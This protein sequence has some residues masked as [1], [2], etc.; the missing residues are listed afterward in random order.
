VR[1]SGCVV[2]GAMEALR[3][4]DVYPKTHDD[5]KV[6]TLG[7]ALISICCYIFVAVLFLSEYRQWRSL[8]TVDMLDVDTTAKPDGRLPVNIDIYLPSLPCGELVTEVTDD[9]GSQQLAVTDTLHKLRM[10]R[11]GVPIDLPERVD[12]G[13]MIAP[14]F[15][16]RKVVRLMEEAQQHL[17]ETVEHFEHEEEENPDLTLEEHEAHREQL[18]Q[19][20]AQLQGRLSR[21]T[22]VAAAGEE[23]AMTDQHEHLEMSARELNAMHEEVSNSRIYSTQQRESVLANLHAMARSVARLRNGTSASSTNNLR[24]ALRIRLTI[25]KD[26]VQGFVSAKDIDRRDRYTNMEELLLDIANASSLLPTA[27]AEHVNEN[28]GRLSDSLTRLNAGLTGSA[29]REAEAVFERQLASLQA[30]LRGEDTLAD[31]YCGS[32]YGAS[33]DPQKCCNTCDD[34]RAAYAER[35]WGF[36]DPTTFEQCRRDAR[37]RSAKLQEGEGCNIYGTME[38]ARV[39]GTFSIAPVS[40]LPTSRLQRNVELSAD[41]AS[42]FNVTHQI[43]RLSFGT[44]FPGQHNPLDDIWTHS[45]GGAAVSRY[46][47]KVV[48]TTYEFIGG[49]SVHTNQFSVTQ[50]FKS[51]TADS[52]STMMPCISFVFELTPLKVRKTERRGGS[53]FSFFTRSAAVIGGVFTVAG[54]LDSA[55][56]VGTR[57]LE[58]I[59]LNK[60]G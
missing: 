12:W 13:H 43:K 34:I 39:T 20:A 38:V 27:T 29:R 21:L 32:C 57:Q 2:R 59:N 18:A 52:E 26:N 9:S 35:R 33:L 56:Y 6:R 48:P 47:L 55:L 10:D 22:D 54:I 8:E 31:D 37:R 58:K 49:S 42:A 41:Q 46:F 11:H 28:L 30:E 1:R 36:P 40:R 15:Q 53:F 44:D 51:L 25:L 7:G 19:Q 17:T 14:A 5:L 23:G 60:Q 16:Q 50:Y 45:P 4:F 24:E 3:K